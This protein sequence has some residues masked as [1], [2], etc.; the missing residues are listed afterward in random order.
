[1]IPGVDVSH[2]Q[3]VIDWYKVAGSGIQF[4]FIKATDGTRFTDPRLK[5]NCDGAKA[6]G[7]P[8]GLYHF[9]RR[10]LS[11]VAGTIPY[12]TA[13]FL[14]AL[15]QFPWSLPPVLDIEIGSVASDTEREALDLM[16]VIE[17]RV[18]V[19]PLV[20]CSPGY[21]DIHL[22]DDAWLHYRLWVAHYTDAPQ[23]R[24]GRWKAWEFWQYERN[25]TVDGI[26]AQVDRDWFNGDE[27]ALQALIKLPT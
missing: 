14:T 19:N 16:S 15:D 27:A 6:A 11:P 17:T 26:S 1:V 10:D 22:Q 13:L 3:G 18:G 8:F 12:Q 9:F 5:A 21:A 23:P 2:F 7:I 25:G 24:T 4:A 20:Y